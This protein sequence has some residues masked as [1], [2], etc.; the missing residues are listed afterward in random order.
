[1]YVLLQY[2]DLHN[3]FSQALPIMLALCLVLL[4][5][6]YAQNYAGIIGWVPMLKS[7]CKDLC[8]NLTVLLEYIYVHI[9]FNVLTVLLE[10]I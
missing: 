1:M 9:N 4:A 5:T 8:L 10:Y 3:Y 7:S 2:I 6:H